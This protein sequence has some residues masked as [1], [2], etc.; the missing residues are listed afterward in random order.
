M[1]NL[2]SD[3]S[4]S[5]PMPY[6][7]AST[8]V[9]RAPRPHGCGRRA[10]PR[11]RAR[12]QHRLDRSHVPTLATWSVSTLQASSPAPRRRAVRPE[13]RAARRQ[14][15]AAARAPA[16]LIYARLVL[17]H[18]P[19]PPPSS[20]S[21]DDNS[22]QAARCS[23]RSSKNI[24]SPAWAAAY[25]RRA[26]GRR[27]RA[28]RWR[29]VCRSL[30]AHLGGRCAPVTVSAARAARIYLFNVRRWRHERRQRRCRHD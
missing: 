14:R 20:T 12:F 11:L 21:G 26:L 10:R 29:D 5:S 2:P 4:R 19:D 22:H 3:G 27:R 6:E 8:I 25:L 16:D 17:A 24:E 7:L 9:P 15:V 30:L 28:R 1:T 18:L 13:V 23:R